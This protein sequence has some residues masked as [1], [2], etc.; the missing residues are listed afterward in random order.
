MTVIIEIFVALHLIG[1]AIALG[2]VLV[3]MKEPKI[4]GWVIHG[5]SLAIGAGIVAFVLAG[6]HYHW[7]LNFAWYGS[8]IALA[9]GALGIATWGRHHPERVNRG[10]LGCLAA[11][12]VA[13]VFMAV[14]WHSY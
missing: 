2:A 4:L 5:L 10:F 9:V 12:I 11:I 1:W 3:Q 7:D 14:L 8:K 6:F 13:T